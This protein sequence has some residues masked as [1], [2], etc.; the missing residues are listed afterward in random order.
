MIF[1][2]LRYHKYLKWYTS[3]IRSRQNRRIDLNTKYENHHIF[4]I[5]IFGRNNNTVLLTPK[6]HYI[7]HLLIYNI[8]KYR[9]GANNNKTYKM[10]KAFCWMMTRDEVKYSSRRY[11][12]CKKQASITMIGDNNPSRKPGAFSEKTR[13]KLRMQCG[14]KHPMYG[15]KHTEE[16]RKKIKEA[17]A[18]Q[19][20]K[21]MS[22]ET[23]KKISLANKGKPISENLRLAVIES[24]KRR[25]GIKRKGSGCK[26]VKQKL[27]TCPYCG[28]TGGISAMKQHHFDNCKHIRGI[29]YE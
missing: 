24:N 12:Y 15:K 10:A 13:E 18:K 21:P 14:D 16:A 7:A 23:R 19:I 6:E 22:E 3:L 20:M 2:I 27:V 1:L 26:G 29:Y 17:R 11:E 25:T 9:Y 8:Y 5:A 4:P 28:K